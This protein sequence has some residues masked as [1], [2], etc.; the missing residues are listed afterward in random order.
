MICVRC[1]REFDCENVWKEIAEYDNNDG[2]ETIEIL[3]YKCPYCG[4]YNIE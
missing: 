3:N 2:T 1:N 4:C